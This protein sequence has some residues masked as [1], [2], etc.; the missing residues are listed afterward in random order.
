MRIGVL[1]VQ[2]A[3]AEHRN[4]LSILGVESIELRQKAHIHKSM[5]GLILPGGE[6]SVMGKL[7]HEL[8]MFTPLQESILQGLP[9]FGTCAGM[10]L[11]AKK[12]SNDARRHLA[13]M[14]IEVTR[15][16][17]GRQ[18]ASFCTT[19][20]FAGEPIPMS[21]IRAPYVSNILDTS[22][23][24]EVLAEV[25][26]KIVAVKQGT[27]LVTAFH[28]EVTNNTYVHAFFLQMIKQKNT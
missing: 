5:D 18:L 11:L 27:Q 1:A 3:F 15:N 20:Q 6:S 7:L 12:L 8:D 23:D 24:I 28:P 2:G 26:Q 10:I 14:D 22:N 25:D 16:A 13:T 17:Y 21:F 9:V 4:I 19:A